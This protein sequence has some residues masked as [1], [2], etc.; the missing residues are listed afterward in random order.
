MSVVAPLNF[1]YN[2]LPSAVP[3][4]KVTRRFQASNGDVFKPS[5]TSVIRIPLRDEGF[6]DGSNSYLKFTIT[7]NSTGN[8]QLDYNANA[9]I[10]RT[11]VLAGAVEIEN[12]D[13]SNVLVNMLMQT[14]GSEDYFKVNSIIAGASGDDEDDSTTLQGEVLLAGETATYCIPVFSGFLNCGKYIPLGLMKT[15]SLT[16]ELY[17]ESD[18]GAGVYA[19]DP[20][21]NGYE[22]TNVEYI[23]SIIHLKD[24]MVQKSLENQMLTSGL[25]FHGTTYS[26]HINSLNSTQTTASIN[27]PERAVSLKALIT[28]LRPNDTTFAH[29]SLMPKYPHTS[30]GTSFNWYYKIGSEL[31]P[32]QAVSSSAESFIEFQKT[33]NQLFDLKQSCY[34]TNQR[35]NAPWAT[36]TN[37]GC[38]SMTISTEAFAHTD[39]MESGLN[40]ADSALSISLI[41]SGILLTGHDAEVITY[42]Y[43]DCI[44][45]IDNTG[46]FQVLV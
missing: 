31:L 28:V 7:N 39:S 10:T 13:R 11:R 46:V 27:I 42:G 37:A 32:Q 29:T 4:K 21:G 18:A 20:A 19:I 25:E 15:N 44:W 24:P 9:I 45:R 1:S 33:Y 23:A 40:T 8:L 3:A 12:I 17:L 36:N 6:L 26:T 30:S 41:A 2:Q 43:K 22:V 16:L 35:W 34:A 38:F 14:Q 5:G